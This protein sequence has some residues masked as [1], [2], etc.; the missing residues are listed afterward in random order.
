[1]RTGLG[2]G[3]GVMMVRQVETAGSG[4]GLQ[5]MVWEAAAE[6]P[7]G[8]GQGV[9]EAIVRIIHLVHL[10]YCFQ[11]TLVETAVMR[12]QRQALQERSNLL[13]YIREDRSPVGILRT[14]PVHP[15]AE[16]LVVFRLRMY[17]TVVGIYDLPSADDDDPHAAYAGG[18]LVRRFEIYGC[19]ICHRACRM[20]PYA[21][22]RKL[23]DNNQNPCA[24]TA[25]K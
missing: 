21:N 13:P 3:Q 4:H 24:Y 18:L 11:A 20:V 8:R 9:E 25:K 5:L 10:E 12:H 14:E 15:P 1:M 16:P 23:K 22:I 7:P 19:K 6:S 2:V 17:E